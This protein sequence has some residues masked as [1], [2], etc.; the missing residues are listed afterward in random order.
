MHLVLSIAWLGL[1]RTSTLLAAFVDLAVVSAC[2]L[3]EAAAIVLATAQGDLSVNAL[4]AART[5]C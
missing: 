3:L 4:T 1:T 5:H 2:C